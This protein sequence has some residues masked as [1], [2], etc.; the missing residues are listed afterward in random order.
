MTDAFRR[1]LVLLIVLALSVGIFAAVSHLRD[2]EREGILSLVKPPLASTTAESYTLAA[3]AETL[4]GLTALSQEYANL[5]D[6]VRPAVVSINTQT[7]ISD[8]RLLNDD[9]QNR[10]GLGSG[11]IVSKEGHVL[12]NQHVVDNVDKIKITTNA[13][14]TY[15]C[16]RIGYRVDN[17]LAVLKIIPNE[18][19]EKNEEFR[20][21]PFGDS[22]NVRVGEIVFAIG[23]PFGLGETVTQGII[24]ALPRPLFDEAAFKTFQSDTVINPGNSGGPLVNTNGEII[25]ISTAIYTSSADQSYA[26]VSLAIPSNDAREVFTD[27]MAAGAPDKAYFGIRQSRNL[28]EFQRTRLGAPKDRGIL[29]E[30][31]TEGSPADKAGLKRGDLVLNFAGRPIRTVEEFIELIGKSTVGKPLRIQVVAGGIADILEVTLVPLEEF[32]TPV[33]PGDNEEAVA[34]ISDALGITVTNLT[35]YQRRR[36]GLAA[37]SPG[38]VVTE[39]DSQANLALKLKVG[40]ILYFLNDTPIRTASQFNSLIDELPLGKE[41]RLLYFRYINN[42]AIR[43]IVRFTPNPKK[44][45]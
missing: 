3:P 31:V 43:G 41:A 4:P 39:I 30:E 18:D 32:F 21:I 38:I 6:R 13:G 28:T 15:Y 35:V 10:P 42:S 33:T 14:N 9:S 19:E 5:M 36:F 25:G 45:E 26:G 17:D 34:R 20:P 23:N 12:T 22:D 2:P 44:P 24:S 1:S 11:M 8:I 16:E 29:V 7:E 40:D 27:I 37:S